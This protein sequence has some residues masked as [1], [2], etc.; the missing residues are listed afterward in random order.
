M[1]TWTVTLL[2]FRAVPVTW[3]QH[4]PGLPCDGFSPRLVTGTADSEGPT[5]ASSQAPI[6]SALSATST[7][8]PR[9]RRVFRWNAR[10]GRTLARTRPTR[11][12]DTL[13]WK[14]PGA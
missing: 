10:P 9:A 14:R 4:T 13:T 8:A 11:I 12:I 7:D 3:Q 6:A 2:S 5:G 1:V